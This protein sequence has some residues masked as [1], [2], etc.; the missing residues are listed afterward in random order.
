MSPAGRPTAS[1]A[2]ATDSAEPLGAR[3]GAATATEVRSLWQ[4]LGGGRTTGRATL[5]QAEP[6]PLASV[7]GS[8]PNTAPTTQ[9]SAADEER[10]RGYRE[11]YEA[12]VAAA[13][14]SAK[15]GLDRIHASLAGL[16]ALRADVLRQSEQDLLELALELATQALGAESHD[17]ASFTAKMVEHSLALLA[18]ADRITLRLS[19]GDVAI[20]RE[21]HPGLLDDEGVLEIVEDATMKL[22]GVVAESALGRVD[23]SL[24]HRLRELGQQLRSR[25]G[26]AT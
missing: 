18:E 10:A 25:T 22:G 20:L 3:L 16:D 12:G 8:A 11:G 24:E 2:R 5:A 23:A 17:R 26:G 9:L 4:T 1:S 6:R 15:A 19:P 13:K 14:E 7:L 21:Q